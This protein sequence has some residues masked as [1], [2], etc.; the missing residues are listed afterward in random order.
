MHH[1]IIVATQVVIGQ[2]VLNVTLY[3]QLTSLQNWSVCLIYRISVLELYPYYPGSYIP[4]N[5]YWQNKQLC[6]SWNINK[7]VKCC[8][9]SMVFDANFLWLH[10]PCRKKTSHY[11]SDTW[12]PLCCHSF[13]YRMYLKLSTPVEWGGYFMEFV[14][15][16]RE[17]ACK[18]HCCYELIWIPESIAKFEL[19]ELKF[20]EI[21][22]FSGTERGSGRFEVPMS[23]SSK[24]SLLISESTVVSLSTMV[25][26]V[27]DNNKNHQSILLYA[28]VLGS[29]WNQMTRETQ[30]NVEIL[31]LYITWGSLRLKTLPHLASS[32][33][34]WV[35]GS[36]ILSTSHER[37]YHKTLDSSWLLI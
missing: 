2:M 4:G 24:S 25:S 17:R 29:V 10:L 1:C 14:K 16:N 12:A 35:Y 33:Q 8:D 3:M 5:C 37:F 20:T 19:S 18:V 26:S 28:L 36:F 21:I 22:L 30:Q 15:S 32:D 11:N 6:F 7:P 9:R 23:N 13:S 27:E 31:L 34:I